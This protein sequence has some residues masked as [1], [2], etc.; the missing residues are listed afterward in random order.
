VASW[1]RLKTSLS[2]RERKLKRSFNPS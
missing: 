1:V 2:S